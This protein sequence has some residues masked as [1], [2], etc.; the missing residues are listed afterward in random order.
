M[1]VRLSDQLAACLL[2]THVR[3]GP[4]NDALVRHVGRL[5]RQIRHIDALARARFRQSEVQHFHD[6]VGS[7]LDMGRLQIAMDNPFLVRGLERIADLA[8]DG[9]RVRG[10]EPSVMN[11]RVECFPGTSSMTSAAIPS[12]SSKPY[13]CAMFG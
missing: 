2:R 6:A 12:D 8:C 9:Q 13:T 4:Q 5:D 11:D 7:H 3:R 10:S 1:S